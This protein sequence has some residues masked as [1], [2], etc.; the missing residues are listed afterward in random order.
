ML[1]F[2][3]GFV[4]GMVTSTTLAGLAAGVFGEGYLRGWSVINKDGAE[5]CRDPYVWTDK[6][7]LQ[8]E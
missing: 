8:C 2:V 3:S 5:V 4:V 1:R 7:A 6:K